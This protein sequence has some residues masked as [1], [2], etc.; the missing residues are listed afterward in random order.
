MTLIQSSTY[1]G[2][3]L[4]VLCFVH[5]ENASLLLCPIFDGVAPV[6]L[7]LF[8]KDSPALCTWRQSNDVQQYSTTPL[9]ISP[10]E[11][12]CNNERSTC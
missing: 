2:Y 9:L 4:C 3:A 10:F 5:P 11:H 12:L 6:L 8:M 7:S 1:V